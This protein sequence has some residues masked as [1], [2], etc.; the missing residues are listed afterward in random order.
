MVYISQNKEERE[1]TWRKRDKGE[2]SWCIQ[3]MESDQ[4]G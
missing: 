3:R 4:Y 1:T 2:K